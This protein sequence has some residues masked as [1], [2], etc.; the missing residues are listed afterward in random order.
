MNTIHRWF[1]ASKILRCGLDLMIFNC[2]SDLQYNVT[3]PEAKTVL[4]SGPGTRKVATAKIEARKRIEVDF[5]MLEA[6]MIY[7]LVS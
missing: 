2:F 1:A 7:L 3:A 5:S 4:A 6:F